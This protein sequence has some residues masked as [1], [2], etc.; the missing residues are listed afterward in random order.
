MNASTAKIIGIVLIVLLAVGFLKFLVVVPFGIIGGLFHGEH[1]DWFDR[2]DMWF[3]PVAGFGGLLALLTLAVAIWILV[4]VY[5]DAQSR[6]MSG[7]LWAI[8]VFFLHIVG[9][10]VYLLVRSGHPVRK[11]ETAQG[12]PAAPAP[13]PA[14]AAPQPPPAPPQPGPA[15]P[16]PPASAFPACAKCGNPV[17]AGWVACPHCGEKL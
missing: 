5:K 13:P 9:L 17:H 12:A 7:A 6:G 15:V 10:V 14:P 8:L 11:P 1:H 16:P 3:W 4:W 2:G